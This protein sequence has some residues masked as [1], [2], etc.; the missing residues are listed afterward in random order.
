MQKPHSCQQ[1]SC[2]YFVRNKAEVIQ[3]INKDKVYYSVAVPS[4]LRH[5][6]MAIRHGSEDDATW[7]HHRRF[8]PA[9]DSRRYLAISVSVQRRLW[10]TGL[11]IIQRQDVNYW[12]WLFVMPKN[13]KIMALRFFFFKCHKAT[14]GPTSS[15][16]KSP[17]RKHNRLFFFFFLIFFSFFF[18]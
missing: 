10:I 4:G 8:P 11:K 15:G 7:T 12:D 5:W 13:L 9:T 17:W 1:T 6:Y 16:K 18:F 2:C 3:N 14:K